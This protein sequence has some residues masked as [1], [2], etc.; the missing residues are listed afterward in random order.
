MTSRRMLLPTWEIKYIARKV[1]ERAI[2][3]IFPEYTLEEMAAKL[4][5][6]KIYRRHTD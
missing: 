2:Y 1:T 3:D 6:M 4:V 5:L